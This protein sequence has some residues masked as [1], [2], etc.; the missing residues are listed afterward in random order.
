MP[1]DTILDDVWAWRADHG[2][3]VGWTVNRANT[4]VIVNGNNVK[5][6]GLAVEHFQKDEVIWNGQNGR[7]RVLPERDALRPAE[8]G[9]VDGEPDDRRL[10]G[11]LRL[12]VREDFHGYGMGSYSFFNQGVPIY[13]SEAFQSP[14]RRGVQWQRPPH[15]VPQRQRR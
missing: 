13:A 10:P 8:P 9:G 7:G 15:R 14:D 12:A 3:G 2:A 4:G 1:P 5:A 11:V 6:Y